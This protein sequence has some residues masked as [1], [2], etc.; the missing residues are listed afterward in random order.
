VRAARE[1]VVLESRELAQFEARRARG[2][3][4]FGRAD[5]ARVFMRAPRH[6]PQQVLGGDDR[7]EE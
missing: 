6:E 2:T 7:A 1:R 5:Q 3:R 4:E